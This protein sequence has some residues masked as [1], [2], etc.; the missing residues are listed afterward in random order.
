[1][2]CPF[3]NSD[4]SMRGK[5]IGEPLMFD[6]LKQTNFDIHNCDNC[7]EISDQNIAAAAATLSSINHISVDECYNILSAWML[8]YASMNGNVQQREY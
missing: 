4:K 2:N 3:C 1:L 5:K 6:L 8:L 7:E